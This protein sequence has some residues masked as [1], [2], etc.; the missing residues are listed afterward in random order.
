MEGE[1][2]AWPGFALLQ[3]SSQ[4]DDPFG[5]ERTQMIDRISRNVD[6]MAHSE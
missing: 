6:S 1:S 2:E 4:D 3:D 5:I